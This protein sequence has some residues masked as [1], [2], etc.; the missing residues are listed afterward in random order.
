M[1][2]L[3]QIP[4][5]LFRSPLL[6]TVALI[7]AI[8]VLVLISSLLR[9]EPAEVASPQLSAESLAI[10]CNR[11]DW[12][13]LRPIDEYEFEP[14]SPT[15]D[16]S[17]QFADDAELAA[18]TQFT[19]TAPYIEYAS[20]QSTLPE[21]Y[22]LRWRIGI[23]IPE[24]NPLYFQWP[25]TR[26]GWYLNWSTG[27]AEQNQLA[28]LIQNTRM[29]K[30]DEAALGMTFVPMVR[31]P[32]GELRPSP[33]QLMTLAA[34]YPGRTWLI[35]NEP[36][37][38]WQDNATPEQY[39]FAF[40]CAQAAIRGGD[41]TAKIGFA[42]LSQIT[43]LRIQY[44]NRVWDYYNTIF[45]HEMDVDVWNMHA[46]VLR[47]ERDSWG[48]HIPPGFDDVDSGELWEMED[49]SNLDLIRGQ[50]ELM[51][52]WMLEH[53]QQDKPLIISEYGI[54]L[55]SNYG[56]P[57]H[58][59]V[60]FMWGSFDLFNSLRD[61]ELGYPEDDYRLVQ[62]WVWF[63][64]RYDLYPTGDLFNPDDSAGP[65]MRAMSAYIEQNMEIPE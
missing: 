23:G 47:E 51:R 5:Y 28:G 63:S 21:P 50:I 14:I 22:T 1:K 53:G 15:P 17:A 27:H 9:P 62:R 19:R 12:L 10:A 33:E 49:H 59:V 7:G 57:L 44:I 3:Y 54:L 60:D 11:P 26:P 39:A 29:A 41:P 18:A 45:G 37:V 36:D 55:P 24:Q 30:P 4:S 56:F 2:S 31:V 40:R 13:D 58:E 43:P 61:P 34:K 52:S 38:E 25:Q 42:G 46:F 16:P 64:T 65:L 32:Q 6:L 35:G 8:L 48:V 20:A